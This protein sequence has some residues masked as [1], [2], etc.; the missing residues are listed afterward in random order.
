MYRYDVAIHIGYNKRMKILIATHNPGKLKELQNGL[1]ILKNHGCEIVSLKELSIDN[2]PEETGKNFQENS[3]LK[4]KYYSQISHLPT[5]SDDGG[6]GIPI[7]NGEPGVKS[8]RWKGYDATDEELIQYTL[9]KLKKYHGNDRSA[10]LQTC[11]TFYDPRT[12]TSYSETEQVD[13]CI[14]D[15]ASKKRIAGYPF[16]A[17]FIV[18]KFNKYYDDLTEKEH[19]EINHRI[20]AL[21]RLANRIE[22]WYY[23]K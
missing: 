2:E 23:S 21:R 15:V 19:N 20:I 10:Y 1:L 12:R 18:K 6:L 14:A 22:N 5:I 3:L 8:R 16:R 9:E 7:L 13:G 17:V 4:A 11:V